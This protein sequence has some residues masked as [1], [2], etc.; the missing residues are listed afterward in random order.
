MDEA[1]DDLETVRNYL[2]RDEPE[3]RFPVIGAKD[4]L[5]KALYDSFDEE[6]ADHYVQLLEDEKL[7]EFEYVVYGGEEVRSGS[8][9]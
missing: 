7:D 4:R 5:T 9:D 2:N 1:Y 8:T 6:T 3:A